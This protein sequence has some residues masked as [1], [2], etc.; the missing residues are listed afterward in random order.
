LV[1]EVYDLLL[2]KLTRNSPKD[3]E[4]VQFVIEK[5]KLSF[6]K[7]HERFMEM[8]PVAGDRRRHELTLNLWQDFFPSGK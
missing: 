8:R 1:P 7:L 4:D 3:R 2:S 6:A 5:E